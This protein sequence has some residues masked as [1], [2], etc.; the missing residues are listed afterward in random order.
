MQLAKLVLKEL[1]ASK[2]YSA[3]LDQ[4]SESGERV[5]RLYAN[6]EGFAMLDMMAYPKGTGVMRTAGVAI[7]GRV[8][9]P[10]YEAPPTTVYL[11]EF[12]G[13]EDDH[14]DVYDDDIAD[15]WDP[16]GGSTSPQHEMTENDCIYGADEKSKP[17]HAST[18]ARDRDSS[19]KDIVRGASSV[20]I[21]PSNSRLSDSSSQNKQSPVCTR[22]PDSFV[23]M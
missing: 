13:S 10:I 14:N 22:F 8:N 20:H 6:D 7:P 9:R 16:N 15:P 23:N 2:Q 5:C 1:A 18:P 3:R 11:D 21:D 12:S 17:R 19:A 4:Y